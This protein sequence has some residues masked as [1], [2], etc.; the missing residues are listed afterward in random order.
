MTEDL[1]A[2][3]GDANEFGQ[4]LQV[5]KQALAVKEGLLQTITEQNTI[6]QKKI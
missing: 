6:K 5:T 4:E 3:E 1:V 2:A